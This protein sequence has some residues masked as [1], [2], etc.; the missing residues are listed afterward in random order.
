MQQAIGASGARVAQCVIGYANIAF[1]APPGGERDKGGDQSL[2]ALRSVSHACMHAPPCG[3]CLSV[4]RSLGPSVHQS[5]LLSCIR[6]P[7]EVRVLPGPRCG[8]RLSIVACGEDDLPF[9]SERC[10]VVI[11]AKPENWTSVA[12][13]SV[14]FNQLLSPFACPP[15]GLNHCSA[16]CAC[17]VTQACAFADAHASV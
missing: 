11:T 6:F 12:A 15:V 3:I 14:N 10:V 9:K 17:A 5:G 2:F 16:L 7:T 8:S 4:T 13:F 1:E